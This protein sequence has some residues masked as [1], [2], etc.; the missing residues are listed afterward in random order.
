MLPVQYLNLGETKIQAANILIDLRL[1]S[2][3]KADIQDVQPRCLCLE[4][5]LMASLCQYM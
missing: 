4:W 2:T 3:S 5:I 1:N